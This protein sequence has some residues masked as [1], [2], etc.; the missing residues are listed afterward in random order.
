MRQTIDILAN[1]IQ[2]EVAGLHMELEEQMW[3]K[4]SS[5]EALARRIDKENTLLYTQ[6]GEMATFFVAQQEEHNRRFNEV[7]QQWDKTK[8]GI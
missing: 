7:Q 8:D 5:N 3:S 1:Q 6:I 2:M 4:S